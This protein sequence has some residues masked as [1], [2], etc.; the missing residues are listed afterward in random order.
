MYDGNEHITDLLNTLYLHS[1]SFIINS[2]YPYSNSLSFTSTQL[3]P[4]FVTFLNTIS[5]QYAKELSG[6]IVAITIAASVIA[7]TLVVGLWCVEIALARDRQ[8]VVEVL[9]AIANDDLQIMRDHLHC[10]KENWLLNGESREVE[11]SDVRP[12]DNYNVP[13][14]L[15]PGSYFSWSKVWHITWLAV[16][17]SLLVDMQENTYLLVQTSQDFQGLVHSLS[18]Q[19]EHLQATYAA[20]AETNSNV[21]LVQEL[22]KQAYEN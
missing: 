6:S 20:I 12:E 22:I 17:V 1:N 13:K 16:L 4:N 2:S 10:Y 19:T 5:A 3:F 11:E 7:F 14:H 8:E 18:M 21:T 15:E 9:K